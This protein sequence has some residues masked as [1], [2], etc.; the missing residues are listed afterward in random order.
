MSWSQRL[1]YLFTSALGA[2]L[3]LYFLRAFRVI[4][5]F[6]GGIILALAVLSIA[7]GLVYGVLKT[8]RY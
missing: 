1:A 2:T 5:S 4:T 8:K 3:L 7:S 6:P